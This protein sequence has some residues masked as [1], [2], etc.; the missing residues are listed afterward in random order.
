MS[1]FLDHLVIS[2][3]EGLDLNIKEIDFDAC[4]KVINQELKTSK[5]ENH[6]LCVCIRFVTNQNM[7][8]LNY[9]YTGQNKETNVL[10]FE[11]DSKKLDENGNC[12]GDIAICAEVLK[13]EAKEQNKV[14]LDHLMHL[15]VHGVLHLFG[16]SHDLENKAVNME[17]IEKRVLKKLS[18]DD[19]YQIEL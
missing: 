7:K 1:F 15:F 6:S 17:S 19:P 4:I 13:R 3:D 12:F 10:S 11:P 14:F 16:Y 8:K 2:M 18:I 9:K 5:S